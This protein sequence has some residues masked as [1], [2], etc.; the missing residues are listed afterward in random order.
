MTTVEYHFG[1]LESLAPSSM[2]RPAR[3]KVLNKDQQRTEIPAESSSD[4]PLP[5]SDEP[6]NRLSQV[7]RQQEMSMR[8]V[9]RQTGVSVRTLR[10]QEQPG[11]D[12]RISELRKWQKALDVP[13][14]ELLEEPGTQLSAPV[15][16]RARYIRLMKTASAIL[17]QAEDEGIQRMASMLVDQ[18]V[19]VMPE[20]AGVTAWHT[21]GQRRGLDEMGKVV[22]RMLPASSLYSSC[23]RD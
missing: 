13:M 3:S 17:E 20:L 5:L 21:F 9:G 12:L 7:R 2:D 1:L 15:M 11:A 10:E 22:E 23:R 8:S 18:L 16:E 6:L 14:A 19:E 4:E